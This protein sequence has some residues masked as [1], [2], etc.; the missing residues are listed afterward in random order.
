MMHDEFTRL[1]KVETTAKFY[2]ESI[3]PKYMEAGI[4]K[5]AFVEQWL[6]DNKSNIVKAHVFDLDRATRE[7]ALADC[8]AAELEKI[9]S[10]NKRLQNQAETFETKF[11]A[12]NSSWQEEKHM[13]EVWKA[14]CLEA[15]KRAEQV[16]P[17]KERINE[18]DMEIM[19]LKAM[20]FD[21][22]IKTA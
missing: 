11:K 8:K 6:K 15:Q 20:L 4:D 12:A 9:K 21:Q 10:E 18:L 5:E 13:A 7:L 3:E 14:D 1:S 17:L 22:M 2:R 16:E 19:K